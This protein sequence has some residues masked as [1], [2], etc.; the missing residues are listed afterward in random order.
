VS[1][2]YL[3]NYLVWNNSVKMGIGEVMTE[4]VKAVYSVRGVDICRRP[5]LPLVE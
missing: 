2:K 3:N 4:V 5:A 1:T